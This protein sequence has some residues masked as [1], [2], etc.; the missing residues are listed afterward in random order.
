MRWSVAVRSMAE[1]G[2]GSRGL[3]APARVQGLPQADESV[4]AEADRRLVGPS[5]AC[6]GARAPLRRVPTS[7]GRSSC[8]APNRRASS[9]ACWSHP[10]TFATIVCLPGLTL[11]GAANASVG[12]SAVCR[13]DDAR[14]IRGVGELHGDGRGP[15]AR[16]DLPAPSRRL[17]PSSRP[18]RHSRSP[19]SSRI[20]AQ[21]SAVSLAGKRSGAALDV[22]PP[23]PQERKAARERASRWSLGNSGASLSGAV[24][25]WRWFAEHPEVAPVDLAWLKSRAPAIRSA[26]A[27]RLG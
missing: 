26:I 20:R 18:P 19:A 27:A 11:R 24:A 10:A 12:S 3:I 15:S 5:R 13:D 16:L 22:E 8:R 6:H 23:L 2:C 9:A 17:V 4:R 7:K 1:L 21:R 14:A 25:R